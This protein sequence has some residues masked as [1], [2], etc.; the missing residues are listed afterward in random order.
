MAGTRGVVARAARASGRAGVAAA[1]AG[2][3]LLLTGCA[4]SPEPLP[5]IGS[6]T[7]TPTEI[8]LAAERP[9]LLARRWDLDGAPLPADWPD[10]P[11]PKGTEVITAYGIGTE[12]RRTWTA[13]FSAD[14][15]T[16]LDLAEPVV[17]ELRERG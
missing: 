12:P 1:I 10:V 8:A 14:R 15:G 5:T 11:V 4:G 6:P 16:A 17:G 13:T 2:L 9:A 3:G 7:P